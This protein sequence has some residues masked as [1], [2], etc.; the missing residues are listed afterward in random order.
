MLHFAAPKRSADGHRSFTERQPS[1]YATRLM[2][3]PTIISTGRE[4]AHIKA[5]YEHRKTPACVE[6]KCEP[7]RD[8][9]EIERLLAMG[10]PVE[11]HPIY[12]VEPPTKPEGSRREGK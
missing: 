5:A 7:C 2:K 8:L 12:P 11:L 6:L 10:R 3:Q 9:H 4:F 1:V